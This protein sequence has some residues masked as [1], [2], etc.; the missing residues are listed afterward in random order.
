MVV[1]STAILMLFA[2]WA[3]TQ[4][5]TT[6]N[7]ATQGRNP[8]FSQFTFTRPIAVGSAL[9]ATCQVGQ[10]FFN[11]ATAAG[12]NISG[13]TQTNTWSVLSGNYTLPQ[14]SASTLGGVMIPSNSGL[15]IASGALSVAFGTGQ[16]TA[17]QGSTLGQA[18][19]V[20]SLDS[21]RRV[22]VAQ[23][24]NL[25]SAAF[26][27]SSAFD[28][29]GAASSAVAAIPSSGSAQTHP[30]LITPADWGTFNSK[31][32]A[33]GFTPENTAN[34]AVAG[35]YASL[36]SGGQ[37]PTAQL[38]LIPSKTSQLTNDTGFITTASAP[39][40]SV[41][42]NTG[43]VTIPLNYQTVQNNGSAVTQRDALN[44]KPGNNI[45]LTFGDNAG[46]NST[47][48]TISAA[49]G[50]NGSASPNVFYSDTYSGS[51][52]GAVDAATAGGGGNVYVIT[53]GT[54]TISSTLAIGS[55]SARVHLYLGQKVVLDC[56]MTDG[57]NCITVYDAS[58]IH[59]FAGVTASPSGTRRSNPYIT[60]ATG[61]HVGNIVVNAKQDGT[62]QSVAL[63]G[64]D[65]I[66]STNATVDQ[67]LIHLRGVYSST[68][69]S[70]ISAANAY[71]T[72][73]LLI[74]SPGG[75]TITPTTVAGSGTTATVTVPASSTP[76][77]DGHNVWPGA[78]ITMSGCSDSNYNGTTLVV[79]GV[80]SNTQFMYTTSG[81]I[82][83]SSPTGCS[84]KQNVVLNI[85]SVIHMQ[86]LVI[87]GGN[88]SGS[89]PV[90]LSS[91]NNGVV[92][93]IWCHSCD[94]EGAALGGTELEINGNG[95]GY[96]IQDI[97]FYGLRV[98]S[99][100][101]ENT[102]A[103]I[104]VKIRD[105]SNINFFGLAGGG[106][107]STSG[108]SL[109][110]ISQSGSNRTFNINAYGIV[111][112]SWPN[113]INNH[114]N[115]EGV[116]LAQIG[117]YHYSGNNWD[118]SPAGGVFGL[119]FGGETADPS[120]LSGQIWYRSDLGNLKFNNGTVTQQLLTSTGTSTNT[121]QAGQLTLASGSASYTFTRTYNSSPV[122][123]AT[124]TS[125][126]NAVKVSATTTSMTLTG[127]GSDV[128]NYI[129]WP[130]T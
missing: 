4:Q 66:G 34:K 2:G 37:V 1:R 87:T 90:V 126:V 56:T 96:V 19:G 40:T 79:T 67:A 109:I 130:R 33:L 15:S 42:G 10:L 51:I 6:V 23:L 11:T 64:F 27:S 55:S 98:E 124:D 7:L 12:Q 77:P 88:Q 80:Q 28:A 5:G 26:T 46:N 78:T 49:S 39:V 3:F 20:A 17:L 57:S 108:A 107:S 29:S 86:N 75:Q 118:G 73:G 128:I 71:N 119:T 106:I 63:D 121:D 52:S 89:Q 115:S 122:C 41:N 43:A 84:Y 35:G 21:S 70:N 127:T 93:D 116:T 117:A 111:N 45:T 95:A 113:A 48:V 36:N 94:F 24:L 31:Q 58:G 61:A 47:D 104:G 32:N 25:G 83:S 114:I 103:A 112:Q 123:V 91:N 60:V 81:T 120:A 30:A 110:D 82:S 54:Y 125:G 44:W 68:S 72:I 62:Q 102:T 97:D 105:A 92:G 18:G 99:N 14:A 100:D 13:C 69:L 38:P 59:G 129:C 22:P 101:F 16:G 65:V 53:P 9:P 74:D 50:G 8:D 85:T 76:T